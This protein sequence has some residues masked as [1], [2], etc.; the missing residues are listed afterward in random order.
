MRSIIIVAMLLG[1]LLLGGIV[2]AQSSPSFRLERSVIAGGG[3][4]STSASF[5]V[6]GTIGQGITHS[7]GASGPTYRVWSGFWPGIYRIGLPLHRL[8]HLPISIR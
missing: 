2:L 3:D 7:S 5:R 1:A 6:E 4:R 8:I